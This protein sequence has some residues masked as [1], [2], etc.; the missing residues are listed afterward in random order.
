MAKKGFFTE[1]NIVMTL[2]KDDE[3]IW[4]R[5][6]TKP[7]R[8]ELINLYLENEDEFKERYYEFKEDVLSELEDSELS[9]INAL[10]EKSEIKQEK[11]S[12]KEE[13]K[14]EV[15]Q[16]YKE[17]Q[18]AR[19]DTFLNK[20]GWDNPSQVSIDL[21]TSANITATFNNLL[22][23]IGMMTTLKQEQ[24]MQFNYYMTSQEFHFVHAGQND[25]II[26]QN[27]KVIEQNDRIIEL[28]EQ[29]TNKF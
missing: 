3:R 23:S 21:L 22:N 11:L 18:N 25:E 13:N 17:S 8:K 1:T 10:R 29:L 9:K 12:I 15:Q 20:R 2:A 19:V 7:Q 27:N 28:L 14:K 6:L 4:Y 5:H 16:A 26:K 24:Q